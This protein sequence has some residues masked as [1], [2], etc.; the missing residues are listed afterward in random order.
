MTLRIGKE[1]VSVPTDGNSFWAE[2]CCP[3]GW[4]SVSS[5]AFF[6]CTSKVMQR[7][8]FEVN[9]V[10]GVPFTKSQVEAVF[11]IEVQSSR[12]IQWRALQRSTVGRWFSCT[13]SGEGFDDAVFEMHY[14][15]AV[16]SNVTDV[17]V[18]LV[19]Q[20]NRVWSV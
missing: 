18:S 10:N 16:V 20:R 17:E 14:S 5:E 7:L 1:H 12:T 3:P 4:P 6:T 9:P 2:K 8:S 19:I 15:D 13:R 11:P